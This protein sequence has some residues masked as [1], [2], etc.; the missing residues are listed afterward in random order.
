MHNDYF[1]VLFHD[2]P[3]KE[4]IN[5]GCMELDVVL[6]TSQILDRV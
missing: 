3:L 1:I 4:Y 6:S 5:F 2:N